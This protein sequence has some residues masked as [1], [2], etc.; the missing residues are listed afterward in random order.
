MD[1]SPER[2]RPT[3]VTLLAWMVLSLT[4]W[5]GLRLYAAITQWD[6]L[7]KYAFRPSIHTVGI[8]T[9]AVGIGPFYIAASGAF[10]FLAGL[11]LVWGLFRG[12]PWARPT[13]L[14]EAVAYAAWYWFD[15][16]AFQFPHPNW[17]FALAAT[18]LLLGFTGFT[19]FRRRSITF[20]KYP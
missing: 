5:N 4:V 10:W 16:L 13:L 14:A 15:R 3:S 1:S 18:L 2:K 7:R 17:P 6:L 9:L 19:V 20:F 11:P 12:K 8:I